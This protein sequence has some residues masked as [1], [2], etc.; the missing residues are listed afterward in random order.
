VLFE[1]RAGFFVSH[2]QADI[3]EDLQGGGVGA[4]DLLLSE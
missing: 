4:F 2:Q 1:D 3:L